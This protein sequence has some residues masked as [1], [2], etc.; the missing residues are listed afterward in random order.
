MIPHGLINIY[1]K[2]YYLL[3]REERSVTLRDAHRYTTAKLGYSCNQAGFV[4]GVID[5]SLSAFRAGRTAM[6]LDL[7]R[8][9]VTCWQMYQITKGN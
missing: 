6:A 4:Y 1:E 8:G 5:I 2:G 3:Y 7:T 9:N